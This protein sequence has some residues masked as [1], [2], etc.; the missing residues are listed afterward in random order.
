MWLEALATRILEVDLLLVEKG[1]FTE[2]LRYQVN[3][4]LAVESV[5]EALVIVK[6]VL[7][8]VQQPRLIVL[9]RLGEVHHPL[10]GGLRPG[11]HLRGPLT[12]KLNYQ[13]HEALLGKLIGPESQSG[14]KAK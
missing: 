1:L 3:E 14:K 4:P 5:V 6:E 2:Q 12:T 11:L 8:S 13:N 10:T 9:E 7:Q